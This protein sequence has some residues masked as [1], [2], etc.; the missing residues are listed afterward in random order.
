[1]K[2]A[3]SPSNGWIVPVLAGRAFEQAQR[4]RADRDQPP[5]RR[6]RCVEPLGGRG[7][8]PAPFGVHRDARSVSSALTGRKVPA[9]T[10]R[11]SVSRPMPAL[12]ERRDQPGGEVQ[13]RGRRG[14]RALLA[15]EHR[16]VIV[17]V[18]RVGRPRC[19]AM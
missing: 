14:D 6:P 3:V 13:R 17:A 7:V 8:D 10:C 1:M 5:A 16:L 9:P 12:V 18:G 19:E 15:R 2:I 11:V 4:G